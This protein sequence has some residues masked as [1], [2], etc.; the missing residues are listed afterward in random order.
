[1]R[2]RPLYIETIEAKTLIFNNPEIVAT[3]Y[4]YFI[5]TI[6][7]SRLFQIETVPHIFK[8]VYFFCKYTLALICECAAR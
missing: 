6:H 2:Q 1:M 4:I 7:I 3:Y 8:F 5:F